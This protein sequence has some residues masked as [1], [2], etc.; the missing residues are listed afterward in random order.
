[1]STN[2]LGLPTAFYDTIQPYI[3]HTDGQHPIADTP[4]KLIVI[5][6]SAL[7]ARQAF[8]E[9]QELIAEWTVSAGASSPLTDDND[10]FEHIHFWFGSLEVPAKDKNQ[11]S[12]NE[13][14][15]LIHSL[16]EQSS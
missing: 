2:N 3:F 1:M 12:W 6:K 15:A 13:L 14:T 7:A 8:P 4:Q 16:D 11:D 10:L 5:W 9:K